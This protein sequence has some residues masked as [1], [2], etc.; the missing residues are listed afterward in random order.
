[1]MELFAIEPTTL[2]DER[3]HSHVIDTIRVTSFSTQ[4]MVADLTGFGSRRFCEAASFSIARRYAA[5]LAAQHFIAQHL[6]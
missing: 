6:Y 3:H 5:G 1:M 2:S 4:I